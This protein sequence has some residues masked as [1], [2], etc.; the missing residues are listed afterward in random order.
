M[1][2]IFCFVLFC[3]RQGS[4]GKLTIQNG[5]LKMIILDSKNSKKRKS[6]FLP[7]SFLL[8][9]FLHLCLS[10]FFFFFLIPSLVFYVGEGKVKAVCS[11]HEERYR[12]YQN[13]CINCVLFK[14]KTLKFSFTLI[15]YE[16]NFEPVPSLSIFDSRLNCLPK[17]VNV[18]RPESLIR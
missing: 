7:L 16:F 4:L 8:L 6:T 12:T 15:K 17:V 10:S 1:G 18:I 9:F 2:S 14:T 11:V 5:S 13:K 3:M